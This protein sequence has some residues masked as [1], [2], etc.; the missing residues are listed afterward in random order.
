ML[1]FVTSTIAYF[2]ASYFV[3]RYLEGL[4]IEKSLSRGVIVFL[5]ASIVA[6][7]VGVLTP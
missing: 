7:G 1:G 3:S 2:V 5:V 4:G 6:Y